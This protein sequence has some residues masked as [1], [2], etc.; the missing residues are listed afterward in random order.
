MPG[1]PT[2][3]PAILWAD[4]AQAGWLA[5]VVERAGLAVVGVGSPEPGRAGALAAAMGL[6]LGATRVWDDLRA[7]LAT[8]DADLVLLAAP[9]DFAGGQRQGAMD[10]E[11][12]S[13]LAAC[14]ARGVRIA[15][16]EPMPASVLQLGAAVPT[17]SIDAA[18]GEPAGDVIAASTGAG[19]VL[20][21]GAP[22]VVD[23]PEPRVRGRAID[24][25]GGWARVLPLLRHCRAMREAVDLFEHLGP[26]R[27][28]VFEGWSGPGQGTLGARLFDAMDT[29]VWLLGAPEQVD[30][31]YV[32]P[33]R[34][35][36]IHATTGETLRGLEGDLTANLRFADGR[37]AAVAVS[38]RAGRWS[39]SVT[40]IGEGGRLRVTDDGA[41]GSGGA[42]GTGTGGF[43]WLSADGLTVD[44][45]RPARRKRGQEERPDEA[46]VDAASEQVARLLDQRIPPPAPTDYAA[47]L[48]AA[49]AALLSAR[50]GEAE[51][52]RTILRMAGSR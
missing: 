31:A 36:P 14:R 2:R 47:V 40:L 48:A 13:A 37:A 4:P 22:V 33:A 45:S 7:A 3:H 11:D 49:G 26:V 20:G 24:A 8:G 44:A 10:S 34:A 9:G 50:T 16:I 23:E 28:A 1:S 39:R 30:A 42:G 17:P 29:L 46:F 35:R 21:P 18:P 6:D 27:T 32:W 38:D 5:A 25:G 19:V 51:S 52:P 43:V 12:A 41:G 15:S